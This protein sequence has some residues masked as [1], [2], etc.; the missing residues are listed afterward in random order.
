MQNNPGI[1]DIVKGCVDAKRESQKEFYKLFYG[2]A[3][4]IC[5]RYC[6]SNDDAM[7]VVNDGFV[8]IFRELHH[9]SPRYDNYEASLKGWMRSILVNTAIDHFRKHNKNYYT[10]D[11]NETTV[12]ITET[13]QSAIDKMSYKEIAGMIQKLS[14][15]YRTVFNLFVMEGY[16][17]EEIASLLNISTGTSKSNLAKARANIRKMLEEYSM[18]Y[19]EQ[20]A[21]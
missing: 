5:S 16:K 15:V 13:E 1:D 7:E 6:N 17:H 8:K 11:I 19:Y 9:F 21:V 3:M 4:G 14:P 18:N 12:E 10:A 2:F 20:K